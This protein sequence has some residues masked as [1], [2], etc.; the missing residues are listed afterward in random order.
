MLTARAFQVSRNAK[1]AVYR[2]DVA[3]ADGASVASFTGTV[4][5]TSRPHATR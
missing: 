5:I 4:H 3:R 1:I 2:V